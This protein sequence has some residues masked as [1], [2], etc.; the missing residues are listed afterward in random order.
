MLE[1]NNR[2]SPILIFLFF[3]TIAVLHLS[4]ISNELNSLDGD[5][6]GYILLAKSL[7][8]FECYPQGR[9]NLS[10]FYLRGGA[11]V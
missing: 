6:A 3:D 5:N 7:A 8:N 11:I 10:L 2:I 4:S 1:R 9:W